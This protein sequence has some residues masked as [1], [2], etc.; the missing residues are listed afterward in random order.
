ML[1]TNFYLTRNKINYSIPIKLAINNKYIKLN[2]FN[3]ILFTL[4]IN[5]Y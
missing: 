2:Y 4:I 1:A 3:K 5:S